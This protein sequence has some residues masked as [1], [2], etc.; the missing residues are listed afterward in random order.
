MPTRINSRRGKPVDPPES[1]LFEVGPPWLGYC[2][3][4]NPSLT[5]FEAFEYSRGLVSQDGQLTLDMGWLRLEDPDP[6]TLPLGGYQDAGGNHS[7][8]AADEGYEQPVVLLV[9]ISRSDTLLN[10]LSLFAVT[11]LSL[12]DI[13]WVPPGPPVGTSDVGFCWWMDPSDLSWEEVPWNVAAGGV[14]LAAARDHIFDWAF[15]PWGGTIIANDTHPGAIYFTNYY[16]EV[17]IWDPGSVAM[18][19]GPPG[20]YQSAFGQPWGNESFYAKSVEAFVDRIVFL[21]TREEDGSLVGNPLV[22]APRRV[23]WTGLATPLSLTGVGAGFIDFAEFRGDGL[24]VLAFQDLVACY[25]QDGVGS[26]RRTERPNRPFQREYISKERGLLSTFSV[27]RVTSDLHF[28]LFTDGW[29][30]LSSSGQWT[31]VGTVSTK[32]GMVRKWARTFYSL[33]DIPNKHKIAISFDQY[34]HRIRITFP[35]AAGGDATWIYDMKADAVWPDDPYTAVCWGE[36]SAVLAESVPWLPDMGGTSWADVEGIWADFGTVFGDRSVLHGTEDGLVLLHSPLMASRDGVE[37]TW[38]VRSHR[39]FLRD[40]GADRVADGIVLEHGVLTED[41]SISVG[42]LNNRGDTVTE[43]VQLNTGGMESRAATA[44][45][46]ST[47]GYGIGTV[48]SGVGPVRLWNW[49]IDFRPGDVQLKEV[50]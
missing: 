11:G 26:L 18:G 2:P 40:L 13:P 42:F 41:S 22:Q 5:S 49:R 28:G 8:L 12:V 9:E 35:L 6:P 27:V 45:H 16:D 32:F 39:Q 46:P 7:D 1:Q 14:P 10:K 33:L 31:E 25:F 15:Y 37:V 19:V 24:R 21:N 43:L 44:V 48:M 20:D 34:T 50:G 17:Y 29:F 23:R 3:D 38:S 30:F 47:D 4:L 36:A